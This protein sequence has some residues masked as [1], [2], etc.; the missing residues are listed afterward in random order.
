[1]KRRKPH[2]YNK[3]KKPSCEACGHRGDFYPL[4]IDHT[5]TLGSGGVDESW[6]CCTLCLKCHGLKGSRGI[7]FM[8]SKF[9]L[10]KEWLLANKWEFNDF[11]GRWVRFNELQAESDKDKTQ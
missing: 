9:P 11:L 1:M 5:K 4:T 2:V 7:D 8:A 3:F 6:N 10:Y